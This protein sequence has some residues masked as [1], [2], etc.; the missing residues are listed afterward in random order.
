M[1]QAFIFDMDGVIIDSEPIHFEVDIQTMSYLGHSISKEALEKYVGMTNQAMWKSIRQEY[2]LLQAIE[3][4]I[5][6]QIANKISTLHELEIEPIEGIKELIINL[7]E[8]DIPVA[9]AS[10]S[11]RVFIEEVLS[12]FG[13]ENDF[14]C[15]VSGEEVPQG[16]PAPDVYIEVARQLGVD[17]RHCM[18]LEDS[19]NGIIAAKAAGMRCIGFVNP[20]S[21]NQDLSQADYI[22]E[23]IQEI[24]LEPFMD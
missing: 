20:N 7:K 21:G 2:N 19:G 18:V 10:S 15:V 4:I 6:Y 23:D 16:K 13:M 1:L 22:V 11:P 12:K 14:D 5:E 9:I 3:E 24:I 8:Y 17:V